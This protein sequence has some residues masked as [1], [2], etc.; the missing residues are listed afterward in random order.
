MSANPTTNRSGQ[1]E[2]ILTFRA[3]TMREAIGLVREAL[4][5]DAAVLSSREIRSG[6][7]LGLFAGERQIEVTASADVH[8]PSRLPIRSRIAPQP[9][10]DSAPALD[11]YA[12]WFVSGPV[13][14]SAAKTTPQREPH[15]A[16]DPAEL[17]RALFEIYSDLLAARWEPALAREAVEQLR[18]LAP[19]RDRENA[20]ALAE[21]MIRL[22]ESG[23]AATGPIAVTKGQRRVVALVGPAGVGKTTAV[24]NLAAHFRRKE[25][26]RVGLIAADGYRIA[27]SEQLRRYAEIL[28]VP[29][30]AAH[31][32]REACEAAERLRNVEL[33]LVD[34]P[35]Q[36]LKDGSR[37]A[38]L[39]S[40]LEAAAV[41]EA[42]LALSC[43]AH[44]GAW[45]VALDRFAPI[46]PRAIVLAK[47]DEAFGL[48]N[49][50]GLLRYA[51][52][53]VS[54]CAHG[55]RV[56]GGL[57]TAC[58]AKLAHRM[59]APDPEIFQT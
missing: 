42:H 55:Q 1:N 32:P 14:G 53:P 29:F 26:R 11:S 35:G 45:R 3:A 49:L 36:S 19:N 24:A 46:A 39:K 33:V 15:A 58:A 23:I 2:R 41:D 16:T 31:S 5:P 4:G 43:T 38:E 59:L 54:Y 9:A 52:L 47:L 13:D 27:A 17:P 40:L 50:W 57:E 21:R 20:A 22:V 48:G 25:N 18:V 10:A 8:V 37:I 28:D 44:P 56:P 34:T 6:K 7:L 51:G 12:E 30:E